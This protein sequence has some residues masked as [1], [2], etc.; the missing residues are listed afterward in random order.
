MSERLDVRVLC[1]V[2]VAYNSAR[3]RERA[4][5]IERKKESIHDDE[6]RK[7]RE[8]ERELDDE[9]ENKKYCICGECTRACMSE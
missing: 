6:E 8:L 9:K 4:R 7:E 2:C 5:A 3:E 1:G